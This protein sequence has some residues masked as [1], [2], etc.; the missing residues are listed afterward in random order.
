MMIRVVVLLM[1]ILQ[2][3]IG[4][5]QNETP[6]PTQEQLKA[7]LS[8]FDQYA[9]NSRRDWNIPGMA[10]GIVQD[11]KVIFAKGYGVRTIGR[12]EPVTEQTVFQIGSTTKAFTATV[13]GMLVDEGKF[14][15]E[16]QVIKHLPDFLMYDP[17]VT[18]EFQVVDLMAQ[19]SGLQPYSL[20]KLFFLGFDRPYIIQALR[21]VK[22]VS[23]FRSSY[24]YQN[25]LWLVA[26]Q[27]IEK[28]SGK[29]YEQ[30]LK[31]RIFD[32]LGMADTSADKGSYIHAKNAASVHVPKDGIIKVLPMSSGL[33]DWSYVAGPAGSINSNVL[34]MTKWLTFQMSNGKL[35]DKQLISESSMRVIHTPK[36]ITSLEQSVHKNR[37]YCL[38]WIYEEHSPNPMIWHNGSTLMK[39]MIA[40]IPEEKVGI[41]VLS[42]YVSELPEALALRFLN[43]Y[44][45]KPA[46][47][48]SAK[49]LVE[50]K[51][52]IKESETKKSVAPQNPQLPMPLGRYTGNYLNEIYG[53]LTISLS[54][55]KLVMALGPNN[56]KNTLKHWDRDLF[57]AEIAPDYPDQDISYISFRVDLQGL[58]T[59]LAVGDEIQGDKADIF[60]KIQ[61]NRSA[62]NN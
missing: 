55:D 58:V 48:L 11:G 40:F 36:T 7:L 8:D 35:N 9:E 20:D 29:T 16:E 32:P 17:W 27:L 23:S 18:R 42:N 10:I 34:D 4:L 30:T 59:S 50:R 53:K 41:V 1:L 54:D 61:E 24:G 22:P 45:G 6:R 33:I 5:A 52:R 31:E 44:D 12:P 46:G 25:N 15:W 26:A 13:A 43:Q 56:I 19:R 57:V 62:S 49:L 39:T 14:K 21:Q 3:G 51:K 47:D 37:F 28:Y 38:G 60:I 2:S